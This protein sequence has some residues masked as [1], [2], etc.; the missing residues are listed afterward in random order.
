MGFADW[1]HES[2]HEIAEFGMDGV[3]GTVSKFLVG[4][5]KRLGQSLN[6]GTSQFEED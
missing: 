3:R 5:S 6:Y 4:G 2:K 1:V